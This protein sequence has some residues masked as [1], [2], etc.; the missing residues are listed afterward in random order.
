MFSKINPSVAIQSICLFNNLTLLS[1][2]LNDHCISVFDRL[3][4]SGFGILTKLRHLVLKSFCNKSL[5]FLTSIK[6]L[7][8]LDISNG[9]WTDLSPLSGL[10]Y[11]EHLN[12]NNCK[13]IVN[14]IPLGDC[15]NLKTLKARSTLISNTSQFGALLDL[16]TIDLRETSVHE[17]TGLSKLTKLT[18]I[19]LSTKFYLVPRF[20]PCLN[21]VSIRYMNLKY[22]ES[23]QCSREVFSTFV[24]L[25]FLDLSYCSIDSL[26][27]LSKDTLQSLETIRLDFNYFNDPTPL[28]MLQRLVFISLRGM[29]L[30][31]ASVFSRCPALV[32]LDLRETNILANFPTIGFSRSIRHINMSFSRLD[33]DMLDAYLNSIN[34][35]NGSIEVVEVTG[36]LCASL[37]AFSY[38]NELQPFGVKFKN[39]SCFIERIS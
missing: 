35:S 19:H 12:I 13:G 34:S 28:A 37:F 10:A 2:K 24:N 18:S 9:D 39:S 22:C 20:F 1:V 16:V 8:Y 31:D 6:W 36:T 27:F 7:T 26:D 33:V 38:A 15:T 21:G 23:I 30:D 3:N 14:F 17:T 5:G 25:V 11:L 32:Y 4:L 29:R